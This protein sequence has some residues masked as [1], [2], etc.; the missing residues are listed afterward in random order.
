MIYGIDLGTTNSLI[1][2][3][4]QFISEIVPSVVDIKDRRAGKELVGRTDVFRSF[5]I[6]ISMGNEGLV[7][8]RCSKE[9]L[10]ELK[11]QADDIIIKHN[12]EGGEQWDRVHDVVIS[13][14]AYFSD[15][16]RQ[17]TI[18]AANSAG[19]NV[20]R[21]I[22]EPTAAALLVGEHK[23]GLYVVFDLGG[24]TFDVSIIDTRNGFS[25]VIA[26]DGCILGGDNLD[27]LIRDNIK[28]VCGM[29]EHK[30]NKN[31]D[32]KLRLLARKVKETVQAKGV[33]EVDMSDLGYNVVYRME[34]DTY[35]ALMKRAFL[36][37]IEK[38]KTLIDATVVDDDYNVILVGGSTHCP[39]LK[40]WL[41]SVL[42][43]ETTPYPYS[44][45]EIVALGAAYYADLIAKGTVDERVFDITDRLSI[46]LADGTVQEI[47]P[48]N[49]KV[50]LRE[51]TT[52]FNSDVTECLRIALCQGDSSFAEQNEHI[53]ELFYHYGQEM[54]AG[55]G[56]V[57]VT[58]DI[59]AS[60][61]LKLT[62]QD[63]NGSEQTVVIDRSKA[64]VNK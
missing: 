59:D 45:D 19:L 57:L 27:Y 64:S 20:V 10:L 31:I 54:P 53:G 8:V 23:E 6:D 5:K 58:L 47:V 18:K 40:E 35:K 44:P 50:P 16:Q 34:E 48:A 17:A 3:H 32:E 24:G 25:D 33:C 14:P 55:E 39:Y 52:L 4:G 43:K 29:K 15:N 37:C 60:G 56:F 26:K 7:P 21:L 13:V 51:Q 12:A 62:C 2:L 1:S 63:M 41:E 36:P 42:N 11:R 30:L 61:V 9:V 22:N 46:I 28:L 38:I 49:S